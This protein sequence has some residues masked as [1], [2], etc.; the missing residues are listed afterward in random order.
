MTI[1]VQSHE[2]KFGGS[3]NWKRGH[4]DKKVSIGFSPAQLL[5]VN[6]I[7]RKR[8][9]SFAAAVRFLIWGDGA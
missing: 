1:G 4:H 3:R 9:L 6:Q 7:A 5:E 2:R 8:N